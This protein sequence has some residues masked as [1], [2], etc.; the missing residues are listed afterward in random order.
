M[1]VPESELVLFAKAISRVLGWIYF[2]AWSGSF[3]PQPILNWRRKATLGLAIDFPTINVLGFVCYTVST[4]AFIYSPTIQ[5]Q[6]AYR[7]PDAPETTVRF[8][9]FLF[10]AHGA[11]LCIIIYSQFWPAI[12]GFKVGSRQ[13]ASLPVLGIIWGSIFG[14][15]IVILLVKIKGKDGGYDPSGWAWIDVIYAL[16]YVKLLTVV[17]KYMPQAWVNFKRKSTKGWSIVPML[18]DL[19]G[20]VFSIAQLVIDSS[21]QADWSGITGNPVKFGL[22]NISIIFDIIFILQHYVLY[23]HPAKDIEEEEWANERE[24]L[25]REGIY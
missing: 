5:S 2:L 6:Y 13:K 4:A 7:H 23:R 9:D 17:I 24:R 15:L 11:V 1:A 20:G 22:G 3:Y 10:A 14:T 12:W 16:G 8:N 18:L 19:I 25:L 21:L